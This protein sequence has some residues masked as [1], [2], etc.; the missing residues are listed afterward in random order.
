[1]ALVALRDARVDILVGQNFFAQNRVLFDFPNGKVFV[2]PAN[3]SARQ[4]TDTRQ[5][6]IAAF[7]RFGA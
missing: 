1:M 7:Y 2:E 5:F 3:Q 6:V 4:S